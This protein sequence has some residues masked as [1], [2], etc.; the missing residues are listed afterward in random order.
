MCIRD[1]D[2]KYQVE[3][4]NYITGQYGSLSGDQ[5]TSKSSSGEKRGKG[6]IEGPLGDSEFINP[7]E[8]KANDFVYSVS[9]KKDP[10]MPFS[11]AKTV[12]VDSSKHP[13]TLFALGQLRVTAILRGGDG[14]FFATVET[15]TGK[16]HVIK[17]GH[18]IG[19]SGGQVVEITSSEVKI[20]ESH[21]N[22][23]GE[24]INRSTSLKLQGSSGSGSGGRSIGRRKSSSS[25]VTT[26]NRYLSSRN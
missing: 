15:T 3:G 22:F 23:K 9:G 13:L 6:I 1:R 12:N 18:K 8:M 20:L 25:G 21:V 16:G 2:F 17:P 5:G 24:K 10:F 14:N 19:N 4:E 26:G 11:L 7:N